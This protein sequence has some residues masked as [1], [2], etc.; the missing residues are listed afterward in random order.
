MATSTL[1]HNFGNSMEQELLEDLVVESIKI[2]GVDMHYLPR[3]RNNFD[4]IYN[5]DDI[6]SFDVAY[7]IEIYVKNVSGF[8]GQGSFMSKFGVEIR[9]QMTFTIAKRTFENEITREE[10]ELI[11]PREGDLIYFALNKKCFEVKYVENKPFF[12]QL[13]SLQ[14]FDMVCELYEYS[15]ERFST[16]IAEIDALQQDHTDDVASFAILTENGNVLVT[17][18]GDQ[19][20]TQDYLNN[21]EQFDPLADNKRI[22]SEISDDDIIDFSEANPFAETTRY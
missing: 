3:R 17:E 1:F 11:R 7:P 19:L 20:V 10:V 5:E 6:S 21:Q 8:E 12:Y 14:M 16:G 18:Q 9:D 4:G 13:G 2:Y 15:S 22:E